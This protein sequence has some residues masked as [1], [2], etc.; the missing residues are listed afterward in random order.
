MAVD[1]S[2]IIDVV[3]RETS[4]PGTDLFA[5]STDD[6]W[7]GYLEDSFWE[8][9]LFGFFSAYTE[10]DGI[11]QAID[12]VTTTVDF[13]REDQQLVVLFAGIRAVRLKLLNTNTLFRA[14]A[15][16]VQFETQQAASV[17]TEILKELQQKVNILYANLSSI[18]GRTQ[19]YYINGVTARHDSLAFGD[20]FV[21][22]PSGGYGRYGGGPWLL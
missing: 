21:T 17:L 18:L 2:D 6:E 11:V 10:A 15:G 4:P 19:T 16:P 22:G 20:D 12:P 5:A 8:A 3:R 1:L 13:P 9:R 7:L 14:Q